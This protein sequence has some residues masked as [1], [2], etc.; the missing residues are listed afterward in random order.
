M[1]INI[2]VRKIWYSGRIE[3]KRKIYPVKTLGIILPSQ[4]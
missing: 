2:S 3:L 4:N 1:G